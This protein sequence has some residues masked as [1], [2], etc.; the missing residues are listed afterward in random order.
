MIRVQDYTFRGQS[1][2]RVRRQQPTPYRTKTLNQ[3]TNKSVTQ[4]S[5]LKDLDAVRAIT[6]F[7][8]T[9]GFDSSKYSSGIPGVNK[10]KKEL[11]LLYEV[12]ISWKLQPSI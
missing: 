3:K 12:E 2:S 10:D 6:Y 8:N 9:T 5:Q 7:L 11:L 1:H 4:A